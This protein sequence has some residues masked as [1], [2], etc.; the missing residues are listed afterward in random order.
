MADE[1]QAVWEAL[2]QNSIEWFG[3]LCPFVTSVERDDVIILVA[4]AIRSTRDVAAAPNVTT[5]QESAPQVL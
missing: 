4:S 3:D 1:I 2:Y 5:K